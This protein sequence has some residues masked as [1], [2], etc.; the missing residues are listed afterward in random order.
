MAVGSSSLDRL[1]PQATASVASWCGIVNTVSSWSHR[2][3]TC[4]MWVVFGQ[5]R[6]HSPQHPA[7]TTKYLEFMPGWRLQGMPLVSHGTQVVH[8]E[9]R[10]G[11]KCQLSWPGQGQIPAQIFFCQILTSAFR[12]RLFLYSG[13]RAVFLHVFRGCHYFVFSGLL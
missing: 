2:G 11:Q 7:P 9:R 6:Q 10:R 12:C 5:R 1:A 13:W 8:W 3:A 4:E